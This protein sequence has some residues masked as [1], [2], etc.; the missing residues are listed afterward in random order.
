MDKVIPTNGTLVLKSLLM[1]AS[2]T[3]KKPKLGAGASGTN[4]V[5][6]E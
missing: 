3:Q 1:S 4:N 2:V 5:I 6:S